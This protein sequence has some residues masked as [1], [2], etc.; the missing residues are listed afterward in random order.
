MI[1]DARTHEHKNRLICGDSVADTLL[2]AT[3]LYAAKGE[4]ITPLTL[5]LALKPD[6]N[7]GDKGVLNVDDP[8]TKTQRG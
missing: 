3:G 6:V 2:R 4:R 1:H 5:Q 7:Y 8:A